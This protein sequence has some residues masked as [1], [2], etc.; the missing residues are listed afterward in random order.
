MM[1]WP[2]R[3][4]FRSTRTMET[5]L[6][7]TDMFLLSGDLLGWFHAQMNGHW[8]FLLKTFMNSFPPA[9]LRSSEL[10]HMTKKSLARVIAV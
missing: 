3:T 4:P 8:L 2:I 1:M 6:I 10:P 9:C 7:R 5:L